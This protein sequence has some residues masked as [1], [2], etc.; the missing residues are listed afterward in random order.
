MIIIYLSF[1]N[2]WHKQMCQLYRIY[3][4]IFFKHVFFSDFWSENHRICVSFPIYFKW[5]FF[6]L[7]QFQ[8]LDIIPSV[9]GNVCVKSNYPEKINPLSFHKSSSWKKP[10]IWISQTT[11]CCLGRAFIFVH[12]LFRHVKWVV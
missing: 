11:C 5:V 1:Q 9:L 6:F 8:L 2:K 10:L 7:S 12:I 4:Y 3:C